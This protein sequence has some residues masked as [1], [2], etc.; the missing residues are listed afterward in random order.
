[1]EHSKYTQ[2]IHAQEMQH[3]NAWAYIIGNW[4]TREWKAIPPNVKNIL[5]LP[6][7]LGMYNGNLCTRDSALGAQEFINRMNNRKAQ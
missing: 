3:S 2:M 6:A 1:M 7:C 4:H 5:G